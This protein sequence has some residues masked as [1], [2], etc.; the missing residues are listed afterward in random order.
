MI[1]R[2][3]FQKESESDRTTFKAEGLNEKDLE[4][5]RLRKDSIHS[6]A[7]DRNGITFEKKDMIIIQYLNSFEYLPE[8][9][10]IPRTTFDI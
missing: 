5:A 7:F 8:N 9:L 1:I 2:N 10:R 6:D 3:T 4:D